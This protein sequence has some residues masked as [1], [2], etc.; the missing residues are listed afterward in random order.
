MRGRIL[1]IFSLLFL[2][3]GA[4]VWKVSSMEELTGHQDLIV[5]PDDYLDTHLT[6]IW[7]KLIFRINAQPFNILTLAI[8]LAAICHVF[9]ANSIHRY[10]T[11]QLAQARKEGRAEFGWEVLKLFGEIEVIFGVWVIPLL[12]AM[13]YFYGQQFALNY[14]QG[15]EFFEPIF[16]VVIMAIAS[17]L[18]IMTA[19]ANVLKTVTHLGG[20]SLLTQWIVL[21]ALGPLLGSFLTEPGAMTITALLLAR[22]FY[23]RKPSPT[24]AYATLGLLFVNVSVGG[25]LTHFA[26]PPVLMVANKWGWST[27]FMLTNFGYKAILGIVVSVALYAVLFWKEFKSMQKQTI[28]KGKEE[29]SKVPLWVILTHLA[30]LAAVVIYEHYPVVFIGIFLF[31][32]AFHQATRKYQESLHIKQPILVGCFLAGLVIH[33]GLQGWWVAP[34]I[35]G[36]HGGVLMV[37]AATLSA[38]VDNA[39]IT[40]LTTLVPNFESGLKYA[41][42]AGAVIGGGMTV[43]GNAPNPVGQSILSKNF[44]GGVS[45]AKLALAAITPTLI[46]LA[47]F[48]FL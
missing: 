35:E 36:A 43:I 18:P 9:L 4:L 29:E 41:V 34:L 8:F 33:G 30:F 17:T 5:A 27:S 15:L 3:A 46:M 38:F 42:V 19:A 13:I 20:S 14:L 1:I 21:L 22:E 11:G 12:L 7:E 25:V 2:L 16:V 24:L 26:A 47:A 39:G 23:S 40:Y 6:T 32:L 31:F 10:A 37:L 44:P 28:H 48:Y 45:P